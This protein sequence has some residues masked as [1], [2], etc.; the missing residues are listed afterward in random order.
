MNFADILLAWFDENH[1]DL[2][3]RGESDP[4][5]IWVSEII[6]QQT[7]VVQGI[8]YYHNFLAH[9]P[10]IKTLANAAEDDV[11]K[12]WQGLGYYSRARNMHAAAQSI[13]ESHNGKF[14]NNYQEIKKLKGIGDYT[15]AAVGSIAFNLPY[16][17]VDGNVLRF[18]SR[19]FGI[20]DNVVLNS[21]RKKIEGICAKHLPHKHAGRYNQALMEMG[22][23]QCTPKN[24]HCETCPFAESCYALKH[25]QVS[26][27]P[28]KEQQIHIKDRFFNYL[29][30][31]YENQTII[32]QRTGN[33]I[34]K[35]LFEF[36][37][38]ETENDTFNIDDYLS[39]NGIATVEKPTLGFQKRHVLTHQ[40]IHAKFWLI[41]LLK[42]PETGKSQQ[43]V[44]LSHLKDF[45]VAKIT[46]EAIGRLDGQL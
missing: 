46:Q 8:A 9:F 15:A 29:I 30:Y 16:P 28:I 34:W 6:L 35:G 40:N 17:A 41:P 31:L 23:I 38:V 5:K 4:Y 27:L 11:L 39:K 26:V 19:H 20:F 42:M 18:I 12:V 22:A 21:T 37:L 36:P 3:W 44:N 14:P 25:L 10:D 24:P 45:A 7:R 33:D 32:Q 43:F 13:M 2:P 1:R